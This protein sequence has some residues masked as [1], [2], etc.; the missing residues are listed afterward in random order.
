MNHKD[1]GDPPQDTATGEENREEEHLTASAAEE[2][3]LLA[4]PAVVNPS[5]VNEVKPQ[6][7]RKL[8][9][10]D[11]VGNGTPSASTGSG[12]SSGASSSSSGSSGKPQN[13]GSHSLT[14]QVSAPVKTGDLSQMYPFIISLCMAI[15]ACAVLYRL[16]LENKRRM[17]NAGYR[18][19]LDKFREDCRIQ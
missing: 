1:G 9:G 18:A 2:N 6:N 4:A 7:L 16:M 13:A 17:R 8:P 10:T 11:L 14:P 12:S 15:L 3:P 19:E 5:A